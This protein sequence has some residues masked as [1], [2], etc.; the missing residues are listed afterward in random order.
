MPSRKHRDSFSDF[1]GSFQTTHWSLV[2]GAGHAET[3][4]RS[5]TLLCE[6]YWMP[7]Y[8]FL[9]R[10]GHASHDAQDLTQEFFTTLLERENAIERADET[11]GRFRSYLLGS[12][13][14]F[15]A[16]QRTKLQAKKRGGD[17][18][19]LSLNYEAAEAWYQFEPVDAQTPELIFRR[20]WALSVLDSVLARLE[21]EY[22]AKRKGE[23]FRGLKQ[24]LTGDVQGLSHDELAAQLSMTAGA[25]KTAAHRLRRRYRDLL[26]EEISQTVTS[27]EEVEDEIQQLLSA[28]SK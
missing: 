11:R 27:E 8:A 19:H 12:L 16:N 25:V 24:F 5:L 1:D 3:R 20:R 2:I 22:E 28:L 21:R 9:R 18:I 13:K 10:K 26:K 17:R 4:Q 15:V 7:L 14:H 6:R 23:L